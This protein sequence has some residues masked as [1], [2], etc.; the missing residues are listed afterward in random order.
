[1]APHK[2]VRR[3]LKMRIN[4]Q[5]LLNAT[6]TGI[7]LADQLG[8]RVPP[9]ARV[10]SVLALTVSFAYSLH[11]MPVKNTVPPIQA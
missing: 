9:W 6:L 8:V 4:E 1:M 7:V 11:Q 3:L 10:V 2:R 5:A